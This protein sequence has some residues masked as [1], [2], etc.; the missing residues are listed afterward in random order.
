MNPAEFSKEFMEFLEN[1]PVAL[2]KILDVIKEFYK[3]QT[4]PNISGTVP[5]G[6]RVQRP[7]DDFVVTVQTITNEQLNDLRNG[8]ADAQ[9]KETAIKCVKAFMAGAAFAG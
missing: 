2:A 1:A 9:V 4:V 6:P 7:G 5:P 8:M 3:I